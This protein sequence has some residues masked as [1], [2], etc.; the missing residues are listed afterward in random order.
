MSLLRAGLSGKILERSRN[1]LA[2]AEWLGGV[3]QQREVGR[4]IVQWPENI[5]LSILTPT[6]WEKEMATHSSI[7]AWEIPWTEEP[8]G[9]SPWGQKES[10]KTECTHTHPNPNGRGGHQLRLG[11]SPGQMLSSLAFLLSSA[12]QGTPKAAMSEWM[13]VI[14]PCPTLCNPMDYTK[15]AKLS[16]KATLSLSQELSFWSALW[17]FES[18]TQ[19]LDDGNKNHFGPSLSGSQTPPATSIVSFLVAI[20]S[21]LLFCFIA[22]I[23]SQA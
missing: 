18:L 6:Q 17:C 19:H 20:D 16:S 1:D 7:L 5:P 23:F 2:L 14:Q 4:E 9:Y 22:T 8:L 10:D 3:Q 15:E 12:W 11:N 21:Y 13:K